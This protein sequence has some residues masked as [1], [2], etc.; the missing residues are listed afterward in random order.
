[1][2]LTEKIAESLARH[3]WKR[4]VR[5]GRVHCTCGVVMA[6]G[7]PLREHQADVLTAVVREHFT[8]DEA[9]EAGARALDPD[10]FDTSG[11]G[12][13]GEGARIQSA[14]DAMEKSRDVL[15]AAMEAGQ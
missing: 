15:T 2:T 8:S 10:A 6:P 4:G 12:G 7:V 1:M 3:D 14:G 9:V 11:H 5:D 13:Y